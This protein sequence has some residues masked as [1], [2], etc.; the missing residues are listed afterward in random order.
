[1]KR[2]FRNIGWLLGS[3]GVNAA[4][5]LVYLALAT[6]VLGLDDF[7]RFALVIVLAQ[8]VAGLA[9]FN[10]WQAVVRWGAE[11]GN[12][13]TAAGFALALD[14]TSLAFGSLLALAAAWTAPYWLP[15]PPDLR[16]LIFA[17]CM[18]CLLAIRSTPT[19]VLRL[20]DRYDLATL[21]EAVLP[22]TRAAGAAIAAFAAPGIAGF[23]AAWAIAEL[24]CAAA[25]W[26]LARKFVPFGLSDISLKRLPAGRQRVWQFIFATN[27]SRSLAV[28]GKQVLMLLVGALGGAALAGG[29]RVAVQF[30]QALVQLG[31]AA[32]RALYPELIRTS[33]AA[34]GLAGRMTVLALGAGLIAVAAAILGGRWAIAAIAGPEFTFAYATLVLLAVAGGVELLG[35][36]WEALLVSKGRAE[37]AFVLRAGPLALALALLPAAIAAWGLPGVGAC[38]LLASSATVAGFAYAA[39]RLPRSTE[40]PRGT[41]R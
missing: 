38:V 18:A 9:S 20:H 12:A 28:T 26:L 31:E 19:G 27:F 14:L 33:D 32:A 5:S 1:M 29:Y 35:V 6:R 40:L 23:V 3:R 30:G 21:A 2:I 39:S 36:S 4:F 24:A 13:T 17:M 25:H 15:L 7:G 11:E 37:L 34:H 22:A 41:I 10:T 8:G 16:P